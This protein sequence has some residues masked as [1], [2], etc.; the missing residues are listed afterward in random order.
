MKLVK[1]MFISTEPSLELEV[2]CSLCKEQGIKPIFEYNIDD[3]VYKQ[4][5]TKYIRIV[6][7]DRFLSVVGSNLK[8]LPTNPKFIEFKLF[9]E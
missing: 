1:D 2:F 3:L 7:Y 8:E 9:E 6:S 4:D 5:K